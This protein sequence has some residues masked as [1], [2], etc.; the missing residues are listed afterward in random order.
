MTHPLEEL[1]PDDISKS[2]ELVK[3]EMRRRGVNANDILFI[4]IDLIDPPKQLVLSFHKGT[5]FE[6]RVIVVLVERTTLNTYEVIVSIT[7][8]SIVDWQERHG[9]HPLIPIEEFSEC[10]KMVKNHPD[11]QR[12]MASR[13]LTNPNHWMIEPW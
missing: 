6:K 7:K 1:K 5:P 2:K 9:V 3:N 8:S 12:A 4:S 11:F 13:G 10:D